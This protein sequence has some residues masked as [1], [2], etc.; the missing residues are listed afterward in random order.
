MKRTEK[1]SRITR[2]DGGNLE[3]VL[4]HYLRP[5]SQ[6]QVETDCSQVLSRLE[7]RALELAR[8]E[9]ITDDSPPSP[10]NWPRLA[11]LSAAAVILVAIGI[12]ILLQQYKGAAMVRV[13]E[14]TLY[15]LVD[16]KPQRVPLGRTLDY[17]QMVRTNDA[18]SVLVLA[19][20]SRVEMRSASEFSIERAEDG[21]R[22]NLSKGG[23]IVSAAKQRGGHLYV[24]T[25]DMTV[26]V[27]GTVFLVNAEEEGSRVAVIEGVVRVQHGT[28][29]ESL[30]PGEQLSTS[31][32]LEEIPVKEELGWSRERETH[33]AL[34]QL[35]QQS[36]APR[37]EPRIAFE[38][39]S[40][41][42]RQGGGAGGGLRGEGLGIDGIPGGPCEARSQVQLDPKRFAVT[43]A[44]LLWL[45]TAA[46]DIG[47]RG[48]GG[49]FDVR[50]RDAVKMK[51]LSEGPDWVRTMEFDV[52]ALLPPGIPAYTERQM[53][54][55]EAPEIQRMLQAMLAER[56]KLVL[57]RESR[58]LP[59][60][61]LSVA[62]NGAKLT[63]ARERPASIERDGGVNRANPSAGSWGTREF[64]DCS[65]LR[66]MIEEG[67]DNE[68]ANR[69]RR[70]DYGA[71]TVFGGV[72][73]TRATLDRFAGQLQAMTQRPVVNRTGIPGVFDYD[74]IFAPTL[75]SLAVPVARQ[76]S[77]G[78]TILSWPT[79]F[80]AIEEQMGLRLESL[81][82]PVETFVIVSVEKPSEN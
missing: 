40:I 20:T 4:R 12:T 3:E 69:C 35:L 73:A 60:Y 81:Q 71:G 15:R 27:V 78:R 25:K 49:N 42:W 55:G 57:K 79:L 32:R 45:I 29:T 51:L 23:V 76:T 22:I 61:I 26:S 16:G 33:V 6:E 7:F 30:L 34:L 17:G 44:G 66:R 8:R 58:E 65:S 24:R 52:Q 36:A 2:F 82:G 21:I 46:Y 10:F 59:V 43:R 31:P 68:A 13:A 70:H 50:C 41:R 54:R 63:P 80:K 37:P 72:D 53:E 38:E 64:P 19:D 28:T 5:A 56:F 39:V 77:E 11:A 48:A 18:G 75:P 62:P 67:V 9:L 74:L 1:D 47:P 14:G